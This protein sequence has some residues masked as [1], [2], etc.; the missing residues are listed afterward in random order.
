MKT[1]LKALGGVVL[2]V[3]VAIQFIARPDRQNPP[4]DPARALAGHVA[5]PREVSSIL[6][7]SC[8]DCHS[9]RTRWPWYS[10]VAPASWLVAQDVSE[11]REHLNFSE[12][13]SYSRKRQASRFEMIGIEV[14][15]GEMPLK[16]YLLMHGDAALSEEDKDVLCSWAEEQSDSLM[17]TVE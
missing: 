2:A 7:R 10:G 17:A 14:D 1:F 4:E 12:W 9:N 11:G 3:A 8:I 6:E 16:G 15:K 13:G 5:I